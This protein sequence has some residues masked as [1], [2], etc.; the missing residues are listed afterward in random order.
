MVRTASWS[1][2]KPPPRALTHNQT[3]VFLQFLPVEPGT[4]AGN[5]VGRYQWIHVVRE[6]R[7]DRR[8]VCG[9]LSDI[10]HKGQQ[11]PVR[12]GQTRLDALLRL[13]DLRRTVES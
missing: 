10:A 3:R 8:V 12:F 1:P 11:D 13:K 2:I 5:E 6:C 4:A 7:I 9:C